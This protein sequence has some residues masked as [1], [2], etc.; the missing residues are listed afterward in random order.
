M[1]LSLRR[2]QPRLVGPEVVHAVGVGKERRRDT[3]DAH[4]T[5]ELQG[6][7]ALDP[8]E[9]E[10][11]GGLLIPDVAVCAA[12]QILDTSLLVVGAEEGREHP[13]YRGAPQAQLLL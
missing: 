2:G 7:T 6:V 12:A 11:G 4:L 9:A 1:D 5:A 10:V 8:R 13:F 3:F